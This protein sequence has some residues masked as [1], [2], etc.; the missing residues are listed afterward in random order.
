MDL[1]NDLS[2]LSSEAKS[3]LESDKKL[4]IGGEW[5]DARSGA[6]FEVVDPTSGLAVACVA[7]ASGEDVDRA[8]TAAREA[9]ARGPWSRMRPHQR[10][11]IM[12]R[13]AALIERDAQSLAELETLNSG[14]LIGNTRLFDADLS[15]H[16]LRYMAG[17][18]TKLNGETMDLA[19]PYLPDQRFDGFTRRFPVG[20]V[21]GITP[22]NVPL[23][24]AV[25]KLAPVLATGCTIVLKPS[26]QTP[27]TALRLGELC[28]EAGVPPGVVNVVTGGADTG[29]A[30]VEHAG[31]DK[32][33]FTGSTAAGRAIAASAAPRFKRYSLE[34]GG[35]SPVVIARDADLELAIPGA[36]WA[37]YGNHGQNC[38]AG[39]RLFV[40]SSHYD[41]VVEGVTQIARTMRLGP[42]LDPA[43]MMGPMANH[44]HRDRV[45]GYVD[46]AREA[47]GTVFGGEL[48]EGHGAYLRPA[49]VT[50]L[51][52]DHATVQEEIFGPVLAA[53]RFDEDDEAIALANDT[54][55]GL[56]ASI[57]STGVGTVQRYFDA[58]QVGTVWINT[59]NV[60]DL[61][62]P[63]GGVKASGAGHELGREGVFSHT[64]FRAGVSRRLDW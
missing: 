23:C 29:R 32:I 11:A 18:A 64:L 53:F 33:S 8:V 5:I 56:G 15:V 34:L 46:R 48:I 13:L 6:S 20:V 9:F 7:E 36:A 44:A 12:L 21:A 17:W 55:Y 52:H 4:F 62:L 58:F 54:V 43:S 40:H 16:T 27:L 47:G 51:P 10:E 60:L 50:G 42:G 24:Q 38:C 41:R 45:L 26:E 61:A 14:K 25:W 1:A 35:K 19:V 39:S 28:A 57:W 2:K 37:I 31:V 49:I 30:L 63:F 22:W 59:H 3:F